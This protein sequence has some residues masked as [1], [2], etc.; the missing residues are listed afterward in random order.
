ML[1]IENLTKQFYDTVALEEVTLHIEPG[2]ILGILGPNG[3]G[4]TTLFKLIAGILQPDSGRIFTAGADF[5]QIGF[6]PERLFFPERMT[7]RQYLRLVVNLCAVPAAARRGAVEEALTLSGLAAVADKRIGQSSKG[8]RQRLGLAQAMLG[9]PQLLIL[10]EPTDGLDPTGQGEVY[11]AIERL[12]EAGK[13]IIMSSHRLGEVTNICSEIVI[14]NHG[15]VIYTNRMAEALADRPKSIIHVDRP[16][17]E[18]GLLLE[19][20]FGDIVVGETTIGLGRAAIGRRREI[21]G[22]VLAS[23]YDV[24][25]IERRRASLA[26]IY[27]EV[28]RS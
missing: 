2:A 17:A 27:A 25:Q 6:K 3:A 20:L 18:L 26:E 11:D 16:L 23:G 12:R 9:D 8:M 24:L 10:D 14:L 5:P 1:H 4:K 22:L 13:T 15:R 19:T 21:L 7:M 28:T